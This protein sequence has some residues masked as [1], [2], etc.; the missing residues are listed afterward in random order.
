MERTMF[1]FDEQY[2]QFEEVANRTK[3]AYEF[4]YNCVIETLKDLYKTKK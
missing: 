2:K 1:T 4:W 3:Q